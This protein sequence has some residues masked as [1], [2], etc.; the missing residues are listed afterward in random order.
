MSTELS[1]PRSPWI[2]VWHAL[3]GLVITGLLGTVLLRKTFLAWRTNGP[4]IEAEVSKAGGTVSTE[5]AVAVAKLLRDR[6][7]EWHHIFGV[8][9]IALVV[10]R[11]VII[12]LDREQNPLLAGYR[13]FVQSRALPPEARSAALH[14]V[15]VKVTHAAFYAL[16]L[17]MAVTGG[18]LLNEET[19]GLGEGLEEALKEVHELVMWGIAGFVPLHIAGVVLAEL[20]GQRGLASEMIHG[21]AGER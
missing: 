16:L 11:L 19:I 17:V 14:G 9:L 3:D 13:A 10:F 1:R 4:L 21:R 7:W 6:M 8:A 18:L 15:F 20:R 2:R 12:A 5:G